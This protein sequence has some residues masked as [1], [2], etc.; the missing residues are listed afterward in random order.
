M[1][2]FVCINSIVLV[3]LLYLSLLFVLSVYLYLCTENE[4]STKHSRDSLMLTKQSIYE[5]W[6]EEKRF[7]DPYMFSALLRLFTHTAVVA[8]IRRAL[9]WVALPATIRDDDK[10][11]KKTFYLPHFWRWHAE[12]KTSQILPLLRIYSRSLI[13]LSIIYFFPSFLTICITHC[14]PHNIYCYLF[15]FFFLLS[16]LVWFECARNAVFALLVN[17]HVKL[18]PG[19][20]HSILCWHELARDKPL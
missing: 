9:T 11:K 18:P 16:I 3:Q 12:K 14:Q 2:L 17:I 4:H 19:V 13:Q 6:H 8:V 15:M 20:R 7:W 10:K 5:A 1:R